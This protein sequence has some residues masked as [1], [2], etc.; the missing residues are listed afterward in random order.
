RVER[1]VELFAGDVARDRLT[2]AA[3]TAR[4]LR[5]EIGRD[6]LPVDAAVLRAVH[7][8]RAVVDDAGVEERR[9]HRRH[10]LESQ[11]EILRIIAVKRLPSDPITLLLPRVH[12]HAAELSL[13][14]AVDDLRILRVRHDRTRL[15]SRPGLERLRHAGE[16]L[17]RHD[18]RARILLRAI[19]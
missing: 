14:R 13:A 8:L 15:T 1:A 18:H 19:E 2:A 10:P 9:L 6:S 7:V 17:A 11:N 5:R 3:L 4:G 12:E 16:R